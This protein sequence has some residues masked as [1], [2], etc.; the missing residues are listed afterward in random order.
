MS[1]AV[2]NGT[3]AA[4]FVDLFDALVRGKEIASQYTSIVTIQINLFAGIHYS[5][6][7]R[8]D[9]SFLYTPQLFYDPFN[10]NY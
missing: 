4:P 1:L 2:R 8:G 5:L 9:P 7:N 3:L 10:L 6:R